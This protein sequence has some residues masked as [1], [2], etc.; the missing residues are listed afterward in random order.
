MRPLKNT[1]MWQQSWP[2]C[3][4]ISPHKGNEKRNKT[5]RPKNKKCMCVHKWIRRIRKW[6]CWR[7]MAQG[8]VTKARACK[9]A[10]REW[11]SGVTFHA[12]GSVRRCEGMNPHT[13]KW[14]VILGIEVPMDFRI[15]REQLQG[16]KLI[17]LR[18]FL[19]HEKSLEIW[20]SKMGSHA[21]FECLKRKLW[22]KE[23]LRV[24]VPIWLLTTKSQELPWFTC[25]HEACHISLKSS[26]QG[27]QLCFRHCLNWR[28]EQKVMGFQNCKSLNF[29]N[30]ETKW[31]LGATPLAKRKKYYKGEGDDFPQVKV[32]VSL[33]SM[34]M[35]I[36][37]LCTKSAPTLH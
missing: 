5:L 21:S 24:K 37:R 4:L 22:L 8:V 12:P 6:I 35:P 33:V 10:G 19:Y 29:G 15:F 36:I 26:W 2:P 23:G 28:F 25:V 30:L 32:V 16:S 11:S 13:P 9:G 17:G 34:C 27:L 7:T 14:G 18:N 20:V 31:H 1:T 3:N